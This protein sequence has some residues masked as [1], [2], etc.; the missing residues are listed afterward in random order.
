MTLFSPIRTI[1]EISPRVW[2][3]GIFLFTEVQYFV[4][5]LLQ[6]SRQREKKYNT[7]TASVTER[8]EI[9]QCSVSLARNEK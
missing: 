7:N 8:D 4:L 6:S 9:L 2:I 1:L 5:H 3:I